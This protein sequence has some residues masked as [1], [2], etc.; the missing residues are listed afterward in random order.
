GDLSAS[1]F[2]NVALR[3]SPDRPIP[4][5][6]AAL[7]CRHGHAIIAL[8]KLPQLFATGW[9]GK[10]I[11][12]RS[13]FLSAGVPALRTCK[14]RSY[15]DLILRGHGGNDPGEGTIKARHLQKPLLS[16]GVARFFFCQPLQKNN[17]AF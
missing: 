5:S 4:P 14:R 11:G 3:N 13:A 7:F 9:I 12:Q 1:L 17:G 16:I 2:P 15:F 6:E 8:R 10:A